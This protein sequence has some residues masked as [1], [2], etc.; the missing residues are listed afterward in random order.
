M[1]KRERFEK[2]LANQ[3]VDRVPVAFFHHF[4][5]PA[6]WGKGL[7][8]Q[9]AFERNVMGH[10]YAR[11]KF[12]PDVIK[13]M[14]DTLMIMPVDVSFV[15]TADD[16]RKVHAPALDSEFV[17]KTLELTKRSR[18][19]YADSDAPVYATGFSPSMVLRNSMCIGGIPGEGDES[20]LIGFIQ[21]DPDA[22]S[23]AIKNIAEDIAAINELLIKEGGVDGIYLSVNNQSNFFTDEFFLTYVAPHEQEML[24]KANELSKINLLHICG[25]H[26]RSNHLHLFTG[27]EA[28][29]YNIAVYAE[30]VSLSEGRKLFGGKPVFGGYAQDTVIYRGTKEEVKK[31]AWDILDECGQV[32]VMLGA[33][34]TVPNDIYETRLEW[35]RE[36]AIEYAQ[37]HK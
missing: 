17:K 14:N 33:D 2:F 1:T 11:E 7:E 29:A 32:G 28:A 25:Y 26:G 22:V 20:Q 23:A 30:G 15:K 35:V 31:A 27:Y 37:Q 36:A 3:P 10:K 12:D 19:F 9:D 18:A 4:C 16:L 24:R 34:C 6:E 8:N 13:I 21:S 5:G